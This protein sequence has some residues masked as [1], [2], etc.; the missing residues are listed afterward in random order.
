[1]EI[2][3]V[4]EGYRNKSIVQKFILKYPRLC[5]LFNKK[6]SDIK[7]IFLNLKGYNEIKKNK[8]LDEDYYLRNNLD[9]RLS[10]VDPIIHYL[11]HGSK[12]G[13]RPNPNFDADYY[14]ET[15]EDVRSSKLEPFMH[16]CL[17]GVK[18]GRK[19]HN[20]NKIKVHLEEKAK[21]ATIPDYSGLKKTLKGED[22]FLFV[23]NDSNNEIRQHFDQSYEN[24]FSVPFFM[25]NLNFKKDYCKENGIDYF[26]FISPDKSYIC[27][28]LLPFDIKL[29]K[30]NYDLISDVVPDFSV[31]LD[32]TC[33]YKTDSHINY[34]GG[35]ELSYNLL[36]YID[37]SF[38]REEFEKLIEE[39]I[40]TS[41]I[42]HDGD[43]LSEMNWSFSDDERLPY[44]NEKV[45]HFR[46]KSLVDLKKN[47]P[48]QFKFNANRETH[49]YSNEKGFTDLKVLVFG[50][51]TTFLLKDVLSTYFREIL[52]YWDHWFF[53]KEL[54]EWY[55]PDIIIEI[56]TERLLENMEFFMKMGK[57]MA[58][59]QL[60]WSDVQE[61]AN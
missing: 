34:L 50:D 18:E 51:S 35:K 44:K 12:E 53:Y 39:Q 24:R 43:L 32:H 60:S 21:L 41:I 27:R 52:L 29:T 46:N 55:E 38:K 6:N 40:I 61:N 56:R 13:R 15:Y 30:R 7:D 33:Y 16:Y 36:N 25:E 14:L 54:I 28:D 42:K 9:V 19:T 17:H 31:K 58:R 11:Y 2:F 59:N 45:V 23:I 8:L 3:K 4:S 57:Y 48:E 47:L 22:G 5:I 1:M 10:E 49:Y 26:F 20:K 37:H